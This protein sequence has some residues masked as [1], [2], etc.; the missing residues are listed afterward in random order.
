MS[1][2]CTRRWTGVFHDILLFLAGVSF[3]GSL[4]FRMGDWGVDMAVTGSQKGLEGP[5]VSEQA[6]TVA[7]PATGWR[8]CFEFNDVTGLDAQGYSPCFPSRPL[9]RSLLLE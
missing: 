4:G 6:L 9:L 7:R 2:P 1:K 3:I 8:A 5:G